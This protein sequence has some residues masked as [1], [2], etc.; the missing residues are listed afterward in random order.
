MMTQMSSLHEERLDHVFSVLKATGT[1]KVLDLG[2]GSGSL[3]YRLLEDDQFVEVTGVEQSGLSLAQARTTLANYLHQTPSRLTL[4][5]G[6]YQDKGLPVAGFPAAA[7]VE[8][9]EHVKPQA[10]ST[11]EQ[12]VFGY[13]RPAML[14]MTTPNSEYNP[15]YGLEPGEFREADHK[16]EWNREKFQHWCRGVAKRNDYSVRFGGIGEY[17]DDYGYPTQ[18]ACFNLRGQEL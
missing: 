17:L 16:F 5:S 15:V 7:M 10:L 12:A 1:Q 9:I 14:F 13:Y 8:T 3:L 6:S 2:C 11:V 18:T 4:L